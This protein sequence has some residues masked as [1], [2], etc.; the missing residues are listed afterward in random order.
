[1]KENFMF[2]T[3]SND[4]ELENAYIEKI[5]TESKAYNTLL[6]KPNGKAFID[7]INSVFGIIH[8]K[9]LLAN[10]KY[11]FREYTDHSIKHAYS[12]LL[13][14]EQLVSN[15]VALS[16]LELT[17]IILSAVLHDVGMYYEDCDFEE[18]SQNGILPA[19]AVEKLELL[20]FK[21][22][23]ESTT[24][25]YA[26]EYIVRLSHGIRAGYNMD[27]YG[28]SKCCSNRYINDDYSAVI[29]FIC[30]SHQLSYNGL[31]HAYETKWPRT[32][33]TQGINVG[34]DFTDAGKINIIF[35][36]MLLRIADLLDF[37]ADRAPKELF[38]KLRIQD[39]T[40]RYEWKKNGLISN[41]AKVRQFSA[42]SK[43]CPNCHANINKEIYFTA[44]PLPEQRESGELE[45][46][47]SALRGVKQYINYVEEEISSIIDRYNENCYDTKYIIYLYPKVTFEASDTPDAKINFN[48]GTIVEMLLTE[49]VYGERRVGLREMIQNAM[50]ACR[51]RYAYEREGYNPIIKVIFNYDEN[52][53][54]L[55]DNG[56]GMTTDIIQRYF[57]KIGG[58]IYNTEEYKYSKYKFSHAGHFGIGFFATFML[59][60]KE[61]LIETSF[62]E[63][64]EKITIKVS[65]QS[66]FYYL[67]SKPLKLNERPGF[68][69]IILNL[70]D[71]ESIFSFQS[72]TNAINGADSIISYIENNFLSGIDANGENR[73][74]FKNIIIRDG[75]YTENPILVPLL[76]CKEAPQ[77][78]LDRYLDDTQLRVEYSSILSDSI[79]WKIKWYCY[80]HSMQKFE[81]CDAHAVRRYKKIY[82]LRIDINREQLY[83]FVPLSDDSTDQEAFEYQLSNSQRLVSDASERICPGRKD[84]PVTFGDFEPTQKLFQG[85]N[86]FVCLKGCFLVYHFGENTIYINTQQ[87]FEDELPTT[88]AIKSGIDR[89][90]YVYIRNIKIPN[91]PITLPYMIVGINNTSF[92]FPNK[93]TVNINKQGIIPSTNRNELGDNLLSGLSYA[94]GYAYMRFLL[95]Q[96]FGSALEKS[97]IAKIVENFYPNI[98]SQDKRND[99]N[100]LKYIFIKQEDEE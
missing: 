29:K 71:V 62:I 19:W 91:A 14:M 52:K 40:S 68:T 70:E 55:E 2:T 97:R 88:K 4:I 67:G 95:E 34:T 10:I 7:N 6:D 64:H 22:L 42:L 21:Q 58:S 50:D 13:T 59:S 93:V 80:N 18:Y 5:K 89:C 84:I 92:Q 74:T 51:F 66:E 31:N 65:S 36:C 30:A 3:N 94:V 35:I 81:Q 44:R 43:K 99:E 45:E 96:Y 75:K 90:D 72:S 11:C 8:E 69:R 37:D 48:Y 85:Q 76:T 32:R 57:L 63:T 17:A 73:I 27:K 15:I 49:S 87:R 46:Y 26:K 16:E 38:N 56:R 78:I 20:D 61:V 39:A 23:Q 100:S 98:Q 77:Y 1:M 12:V 25:T 53:F 82:Y 41:H 47:F 86:G 24:A 28:I 60:N 83:L 79:Q 9:Q 33:P 54:I